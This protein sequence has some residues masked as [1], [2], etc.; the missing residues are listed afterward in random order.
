[1]AKRTSRAAD[2]R[3]WLTEPG[4]AVA[5][6]VSR[7]ARFGRPVH[8]VGQAYDMTDEGGRPGLPTGRE[9][10]RFLDVAR[11]YGALGASLYTWHTVNA[12]ELRAVGAYPWPR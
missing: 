3:T 2:S 8:P 7:L 5:E 10:W 11:R 4:A 1:L 9:V 6:A 12:E